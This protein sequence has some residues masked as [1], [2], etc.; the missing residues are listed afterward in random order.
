MVHGFEVEGLTRLLPAG[1]HP[2]Q[3]A[4]LRCTTGAAACPP[5]RCHL[6]DFPCQGKSGSPAPCEWPNGTLGSP[7]CIAG[8]MN[9]RFAWR[10][11]T[12]LKAR[13]EHHPTI[14]S[15]HR[16]LMV[17]VSFEAHDVWGLTM[18]SHPNICSSARLPQVPHAHEP[19]D[20]QLIIETMLFFLLL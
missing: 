4:A 15:A 3:R 10:S 6:V 18:V 16:S 12:L 8:F 5:C 9:R 7:T 2:A 11:S 20:D 19:A 13:I 1:R 14:S 17:T